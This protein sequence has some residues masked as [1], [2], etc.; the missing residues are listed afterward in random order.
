LA[1]DWS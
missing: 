1:Q